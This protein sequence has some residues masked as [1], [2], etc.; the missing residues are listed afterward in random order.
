MSSGGG[1]GVSSLFMMGSK[2]AGLKIGATSLRNQQGSMLK[3]G[4]NCRRKNVISECGTKY[5]W[6]L[7]AKVDYCVQRL[8]TVC[9]GFLQVFGKYILYQESQL[10]HN[11]AV[12][13]IHQ[14][15]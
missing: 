9:I 6:L 4:N 10:P 8:L 7:F 3:G 11:L 1:P 5:V 13:G 15:T 12:F 2:S 14:C